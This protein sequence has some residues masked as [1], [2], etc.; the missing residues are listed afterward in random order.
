[1]ISRIRT[2]RRSPGTL[3]SRFLAKRHAARARP[4]VPADNHDAHRGPERASSRDGLFAQRARE[5]KGG[6]AP[7]GVEAGKHAARGEETDRGPGGPR[8]EEKK[9][10][11][12]GKAWKARENC[13]EIARRNEYEPGAEHRAGDAQRRPLEHD[14]LH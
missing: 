9:V 14:L 8:L 3:P 10:D 2:V 12:R 7:R 11:R 13:I 1:M 5:R 6:R 4:R